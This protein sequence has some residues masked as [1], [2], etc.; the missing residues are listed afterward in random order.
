MSL[1]YGFLEFISNQVNHLLVC[2]RLCL[3]VKYAINQNLMSLKH[4]VSKQTLVWFSRLMSIYSTARIHIHDQ[5]YER[6]R[7]HVMVAASSDLHI[8]RHS[9]CRLC[10]AWRGYICVNHKWRFRFKLVRGRNRVSF[11]KIIEFLEF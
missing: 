5:F 3:F 6:I 8:G 1:N 7:K 4:D 11:C 2:I 9:G 10:R